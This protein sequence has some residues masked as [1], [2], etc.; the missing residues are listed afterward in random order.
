[1]TKKPK[2]K[3]TTKSDK[4]HSASDVRDFDK[5]LKVRNP[6][7]I[8]GLVQK[9]EPNSTSIGLRPGEKTET[10]KFEGKRHHVQIKGKDESRDVIVPSGQE[11]SPNKSPQN[12][13]TLPHDDDDA[14]NYYEKLIKNHYKLDYNNLLENKDNEQNAQS[15]MNHLTEES[16]KREAS[17]SPWPY[18]GKYSYGADEE[19]GKKYDSIKQDNNILYGKSPFFRKSPLLK[20]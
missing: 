17:P 8:G 15:S 3:S 7:E 5:F 20:D 11:S 13:L 4:S 18:P 6:E 2:M 16:N 14:L 10:L 1:M 19:E 9:K 12:N